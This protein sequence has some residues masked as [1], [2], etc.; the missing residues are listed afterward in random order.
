M[1]RDVPI[2]DPSRPLV[3]G[4]RLDQP[5]FHAR[6]EAMPHGTQA[7]LIGGVVVLP[8]P[9]WSRLRPGPTRCRGL[10]ELL[11]GE[12]PRRRGPRSRDDNPRFEERTAA[13]CPPS[14]PP[15]VWRPNPDRAWIRP[16][17]SELVVEIAQATR[18]VDLGPKLADYEQASV[19][20]YVVRA[21]DP[22]EV[23]W[24]R[25]ENGSLVPLPTDADGLYRSTLFPG[26]W[27][28][29][30]AAPERR[31]QTASGGARSGPGHRGTRRARGSSCRLQHGLKSTN[32]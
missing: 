31:Y 27:L 6:Y 23:L 21:L 16:R 20:E 25:Q 18:Y 1:P 8:S 29:P 12:H 5:T 13:R 10:A 7:E 26:L 17:R 4:E 15:G 2:V 3:E 28:E 24:F 32:C 30:Q 22:D 9:A 19:L 14:D 11:W